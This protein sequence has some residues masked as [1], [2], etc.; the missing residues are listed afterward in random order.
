MLTK[1]AT[2]ISVNVNNEAN[3]KLLFN[4]YNKY[5]VTKI[6]SIEINIKEL[7]NGTTW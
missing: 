1:L 6:P 2:I 4:G 3:P 7:F 5:T